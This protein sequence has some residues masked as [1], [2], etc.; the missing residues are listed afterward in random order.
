MA[1]LGERIARIERHSD[2]SISHDG[3][4]LIDALDLVLD[5]ATERE[6]LLAEISVYEQYDQCTCGQSCPLHPDDGSLYGDSEPFTVKDRT[7][8][9][10]A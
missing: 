1:T 9:A 7:E 3:I 4:S 8:I 2:G 6:R 5:L 10:P